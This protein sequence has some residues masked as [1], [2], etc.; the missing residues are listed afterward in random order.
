MRID[1]SVREYAE[2]VYNIFPVATWCVRLHECGNL[3]HCVQLSTA[4]VCDQCSQWS[5]S[6]DRIQ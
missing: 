5:R 3:Q 2:F 4:N 1:P 6:P